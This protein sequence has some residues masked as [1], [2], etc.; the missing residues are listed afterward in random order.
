MLDLF[1]LRNS[2]GSL[3]HFRVGIPAGQNKMH[4]RRLAVYQPQYLGKVY[5]LELE[6]IVDFVKDYDIKIAPEA[7]FS[8]AS[9]TA[10]WAFAL[11]SA[12]G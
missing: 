10:S 3:N 1:H 5:V 12:Y 4:Q 2:V 6:C 11:C 8:L 9:F 7:S